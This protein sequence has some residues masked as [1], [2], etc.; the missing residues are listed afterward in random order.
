MSAIDLRAGRWQDVLADVEMVDAVITDPPYSPRTHDGYRTATD[1]GD[2]PVAFKHAKKKREPGGSRVGMPRGRFELQYAPLERSTVVEAVATLKPRKW[3]V[4][5]GDHE[6]SRWWA[7]ELDA[8]GYLVFAPVVWVRLGSAPR[9]MADGP[10]NSCEW[11]TVAR[12]RKLPETRASRPGHYLHSIHGEKVVTGGKPLELMRWIIR[13]YSDPGDL[14][15]EPFAGGATTLIA[16]AIE[17]RRAIGAEMD[18]KTYALAQ[19]RIAAGYTPMLPFE[20]K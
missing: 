9:F 18:P 6:S 17:G 3:W 19:K 12:P 13:D 16:A 4:V 7:D 2:L 20:Q 14:I 11:I 8:A 1:F 10:A 15:L 5:F